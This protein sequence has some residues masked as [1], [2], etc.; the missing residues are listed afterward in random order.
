MYYILFIFVIYMILIIEN[1]LFIFIYD[2]LF[3]IK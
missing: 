2:I 1:T 3:I